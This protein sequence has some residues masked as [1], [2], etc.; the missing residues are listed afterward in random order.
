MKEVSTP[1]DTGFDTSKSNPSVERVET[2]LRGGFD[3]GFDTYLGTFVENGFRHQTTP[4]S[5]LGKG[6]RW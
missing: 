5:T 4:V 3:T 1:N 6:P 2:L